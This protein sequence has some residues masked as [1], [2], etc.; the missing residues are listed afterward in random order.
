MIPTRITVNYIIIFPLLILFLSCSSDDQTQNE[1]KSHGKSEIQLNADLQSLAKEFFTWR[2]ITQPATSDDIPRVERPDKWVPDFSPDALREQ[3][4]VYGFFSEKLLEL[5]KDSWNRADS[6]D[7]LLMKSAIERVNWELNVLKLPNRNPDFYVQQT[8]GAVYELLLLSSPMT[9]ERA[10]NIIVRFNSFDK[11]IK[12]AIENLNDPVAQYADIALGNLENAR[13]NIEHTVEALNI[14]IP[15]SLHQEMTK[16]G[17][18][19]IAAL[20]RYIDF[21]NAN[22]SNMSS[23]FSVGRE[24]YEYFLKLIAVVPYTPEELLEQGRLEWNRSVA[25]EVFEVKRNAHLPPAELFA[26]S[27]DQILQSRRDERT[28]RKFLEEKDIMTVPN[29][30]Q[31]YKNLKI[32]DHIKP[33]AYMGVVDDLTSESRLGEESV[34]YI[35]EPSQD[36]PFFSLASAQDPRPIIIHEGI[37]G[38]YYQMAL[39]WRNPDPIRRHYID[40]GSNEGIG[41]YVEELM[42]QLGLFKDRPRTREIIYKFMRLRALRVEVDIQLALGNFSIEKAGTY[43]EKTVPLDYTTAVTEAGFFA[44]NPGQAITY[45]I[46][47]LQIIKAISDAKIMQG[48]EFNLRHFH[49]YLMENGNVPIALLRWEYLGLRDE[50][51]QFFDE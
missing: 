32:P 17:E 13:Q 31:H 11:T 7:Y 3:R 6:V 41:F 27:E 43:L 8:L 21:L 5:S 51:G 50:I 29:W 10:K 36:L 24:G 1:I 49:D 47:K 35:N 44:Y 9:V 37:P 34:K 4:E 2:A 26:S 22:H 19:A 42:L 38:H 48:D 30:L 39:S 12:D 14:I 40:S 18:S 20:E 46:G 28:I 33:L 15:P 23:D 25:L 45:Q 16:S